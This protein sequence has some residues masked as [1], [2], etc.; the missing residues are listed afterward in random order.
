MPVPL[1]NPGEPTELL[2][3]P[4]CQS[5][6]GLKDNPWLGPLLAFLA[7]PKSC[8]SLLGQGQWETLTLEGRGEQDTLLSSPPWP[9]LSPE[10]WPIPSLQSIT[11][12]GLG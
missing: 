8:G 12:P 9:Q 4:G 5:Y 11:G 3:L 6:G 2:S 1:A 7:D 10:A